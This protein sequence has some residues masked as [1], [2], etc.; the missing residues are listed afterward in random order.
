MQETPNKEP[1]PYA[2]TEDITGRE[3]AD[4]AEEIIG[5]P[6]LRLRELRDEE[7]RI[8]AR[9]K[10]ECALSITKPCACQRVAI[11]FRCPSLFLL[12]RTQRVQSLVRSRHAR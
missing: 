9:I 11:V 8:L 5:Q 12:S 2:R 1:R 3:S 4:Q 6:I 10:G 7:H